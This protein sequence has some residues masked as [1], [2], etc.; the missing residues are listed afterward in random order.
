MQLLKER[1]H[2]RFCGRSLPF[3]HSA[4]SSTTTCSASGSFCPQ[5]QTPMVQ[6]SST[7]WCLFNL[8]ISRRSSW[9]LRTMDRTWSSFQ[10]VLS[11][12][13]FLTCFAESEKSIW[14]W[15]KVS[16]CPEASGLQ[17]SSFDIHFHERGCQCCLYSA[18]LN[19]KLASS[20]SLSVMLNTQHKDNTRLELQLYSCFASST[21]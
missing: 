21:V 6:D 11:T 10:S 1:D 15:L 2:S 12:S 4:R 14:S 3:V 19:V 16:F 7:R 9:C 17:H 13:A 20:F 8:G 5:V 18:Q